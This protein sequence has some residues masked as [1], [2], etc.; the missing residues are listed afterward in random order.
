MDWKDKKVLVTGGAGFIG[1]H[2]A[3]ALKARGASVCIADN[4]W[5]GRLANLKDADGHDI[6]DMKRDFYELDLSDYQNCLEVA[7]DQ[8]VVFHLAD[9]VAGINY[10]FGHEYSLFHQNIVINTNMLQ[11]AIQKHVKTYVYVGTACSY[12]MEKQ[13][14]LNAPPLKEDDAYPANPESGYGWSKLM[15]EYECTLAEAER[16]IDVAILRL[17]NVYGP[18]TDYTPE[19]SQVIPAL[20]RKAI[21]H[22]DEQFIVW[23][24]GRQRRAF[25]YVDDVVDALLLACEKGIHHGPIQ[26]GPDFST[27]IKE[28]AE[29]VCDISGK[30]IDIVY[31]ESKREGDVDRAA[32]W[33]KAKDTLGWYPR[34]GVYEGLSATYQ[35][36]QSD[37]KIA[38]CSQA[39]D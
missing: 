38:G 6:I 37:M 21:R 26:I 7:Q 15:G 25:V 33:S 18:R 3:H 16:L 32:D 4:L 17:H 12:P 34:T 5:R 14:K 30:N 31:D 22:P 10:V 29:M 11:A 39:R 13:C 2:L 35:W 8:E 27:S 23:G 24:S 20:I 1:S 9:I 28:I 19:R 36:M